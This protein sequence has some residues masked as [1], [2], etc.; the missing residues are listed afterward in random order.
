MTRALDSTLIHPTAVIHPG[1]EIGAGSEIGP[2]CVV[3]P[4][5]EIGRG[6]RL[7]AHVHLLGRTILGEECAVG[8]GT[9][10]GGEPQDT[11]YAGEP[12]VVRIGARCRFHEHVTVHRATGEG[13]ETVLGDRVLMMAGSHAGHNVVV[14]NDT[15]LVNH[16]ILAGHVRVEDHAYLSGHS[17]VHQFSRIGRLSLTA[18]GAIVTRDVPPFAIVTGSYPLR[19]RAPNTIGM[20]RAG[21]S[22]EERSAV[23]RAFARIFAPGESLATAAQALVRDPVPPVAEL[24]RFILESKRGICARPLRPASLDRSPSDEPPS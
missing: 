4:G 14:G 11:A 16:C 3:E 13:N 20:R 5:V 15:V 17:G 7:Q 8:S 12:T 9:V 22:S 21:F 6:C 23:R 1:A 10:L 18:G 19:F 2:F 24:G